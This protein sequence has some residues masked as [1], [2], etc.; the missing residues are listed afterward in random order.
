MEV[1]ENE[2]GRNNRDKVVVNPLVEEASAA[3]G[4]R[5]K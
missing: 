1:H 3:P 2:D 4:S 5:G